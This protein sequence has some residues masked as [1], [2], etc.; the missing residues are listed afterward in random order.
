MASYF[1]YAI[2]RSH[3]QYFVSGRDFAFDY[4]TPFASCILGSGTHNVI[5]NSRVV[6]SSSHM[7]LPCRVGTRVGLFSRHSDTLEFTVFFVQFLFWFVAMPENDS[8]RA[9]R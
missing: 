4:L 1:Q 3:W 9:S 2:L 5:Q 8:S 6:F 7:F